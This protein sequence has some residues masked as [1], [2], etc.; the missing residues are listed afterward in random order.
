MLAP[1]R[2]PRRDDLE[3]LI[4]E[5]RARQRRRRL[6]GALA[7]AVLVSALAAGLYFGLGGREA[8]SS[9]PVGSIRLVSSGGRVVPKRPEALGIAANGDLL[10]IDGLRD[11][12]LERLPSGVF[13]VFAGTGKRGF[14][15]DGG[16]A[17][18][19]EL[20][21]P[22]AMAVAP[23]GSVYVADAGNNRIRRIAPNGTISTVA[24]NGKDGWAESGVDALAAP[25]ESP[26]ALA[27]DH[28]GRLYVAVGGW[29]EVL[30]LN[31]NGTLT[32]IAGFHGR[33]EGVHG[34]GR[35][36]TR[37]S[38]DGADGLAFDRA[39]D[40]YLAGFNTKTLLMVDRRGI[41]RAP[42]GPTTGFYPRDSGGLVTAPDG[43]VLAIE[44][45]QIVELAPHGETTLYDFSRKK[46]ARGGF[47]P[48]GIAV[49]RNGH[50]YTDTSYG[51]GWANG[52]AILELDLAR[53]RIRT[54]WS[55]RGA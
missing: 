37:A 19:A 52:S 50:V 38:V 40:L 14:S 2:A 17:V 7:I 27:F 53:K 48:D 9:H 55:H 36:A 31:R 24:G 46:I 41:M 20:N 47:L 32:R 16:P 1:P 12:I 15:G 42:L 11:Q 29:G 3:A 4:R 34:L 13:R 5:A 54:L 25:I 30:R 51:N 49:A 45:Q 22:S 8:G 21:Q 39:G 44:T 10:V 23:G 28:E 26:Q 43:R 33:Y 35:P 18:D 6:F